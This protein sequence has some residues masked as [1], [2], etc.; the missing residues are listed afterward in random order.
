M[1]KG[2]QIAFSLEEAVRRR[3]TLRLWRR[4][5]QIETKFVGLVIA[6][7]QTSACSNCSAVSGTLPTAGKAAEAR[8]DNGATYDVCGPVFS[9]LID[10]HNHGLA[11]R[12]QTLKVLQPANRDIA[13]AS[14][15]ERLLASRQNLVRQGRVGRN[16]RG[17]RPVAA[18][19]SC[20]A[21]AR[22]DSQQNRQ[23]H[24]KNLLH[25]SPPI[26]VFY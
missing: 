12:R 22:D 9:G 7:E 1:K 24:E 23:N 16:H 17:Q 19:S 21:L 26:S 11:Y 4:W 8:S 25:L 15:V 2:E 5:R 10:P 20:A 3:E 6:H 13:V 18:K 14:T